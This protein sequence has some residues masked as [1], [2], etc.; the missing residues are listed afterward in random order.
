MMAGAD[1]TLT[2]NCM[3]LNGQ[4]G[5]Q[6]FNDNSWGLDT[7]TG[8][9]FNVTVTD[10]EISY[11][12]TCNFEGPLNNPA[13]GWSDHN[14]VPVQYRNA[15]CGQVTPDG[16]EGGFKLWQT[17]GVT[18]KGNY[19]HHNWGPGIWADTNNA[20]TTYAGNTITDNDGPA[21]IEEI[22]YNFSITGNYLANNG[23][24]DGL[25]NPSFPTPAFY[26][27]ESGSDSA[28]GGI[29]ACREASCAAQ[30]SYPDESVI[31]NNVFVNN[32]G[33]VFLWQNSNRFCSAGTDNACPLAQAAGPNPFTSSAC[34]SNL[35]S[36]SVNTSSYAG[37]ETGSPARN[38]WDGCMWHTS[39]V[40]ITKNTVNFNPAQIPHCTKSAWLDCGAGGIFSEYCSSAPYNQP[41]GWVIPSQ[42][43]FFA[44]NSWSGNTYHG[45]STFYAWNQG[46]NDNPV[47]WDKWTGA[48]SK[49]DKCSSAGERQS[50]AC[51]GPFGQDAGSSYDSS[52]AA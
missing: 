19:I 7:L 40:K 10:N 52:P 35:P 38:W 29:P 2:H 33:S 20:N 43:T 31:S 14:A 32:S 12:D 23:W 3:T 42:L 44:G 50:G 22:S 48:L 15:H 24:A 6:S 4:Y 5:F 9:P 49:G 26:V 8:G 11:N 16:N 51:T 18:I 46:N 36:A 39:N 21:I 34:R 25:G 13:I 47:S 41:G 17:N 45:P 1:N 37:Q 27:S 30:P 28:S